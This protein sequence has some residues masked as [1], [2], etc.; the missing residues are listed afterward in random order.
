MRYSFKVP[1]VKIP[2]FLSKNF[3]V[4]FS[5]WLSETIFYPTTQFLRRAL[6]SYGLRQIRLQGFM[7]GT[8]YQYTFFAPHDIQW[9]VKKIVEDTF[10]N[11]L[12]E[13][14]KNNWFDLGNQP[15]LAIPFYFTNE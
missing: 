11:R 9:I 13:G 8:P 10:A 6:T 12:A 3:K 4:A 14:F 1:S 7:E 15:S 2:F 5:N